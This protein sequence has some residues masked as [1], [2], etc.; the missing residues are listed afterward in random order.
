MK[1]PLEVNFKKFLTK[2]YWIRWY[3]N[4]IHIPSIVGRITTEEQTL[5]NECRAV[6]VSDEE[7]IESIKNYDNLSNGAE[8]KKKAI[9]R[10]M[11][12]LTVIRAK[13]LAKNMI[14]NTVEGIQ[15][16]GKW[17]FAE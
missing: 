9:E 1:S 10:I 11:E 12:A 17:D 5:W 4:D 14:L 8:E 15:K 6:F 13:Q 3:P 2:E 7:M 16:R